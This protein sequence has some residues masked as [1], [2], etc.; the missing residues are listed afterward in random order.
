MHI[1]VQNLAQLVG[2]LLFVIGIAGVLNQWLS[3]GSFSWASFVC[4]LLGAGSWGLARALSS[5]TFAEQAS[6]EEQGA[7]NETTE[8]QE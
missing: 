6:H 3:T 1:A 7:E 5:F 2:F 8:E 4:L